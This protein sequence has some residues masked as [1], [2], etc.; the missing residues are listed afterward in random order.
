MTWCALVPCEVPKLEV[1]SSGTTDANF[2]GMYVELTEDALTF[3]EHEA[4]KMPYMTLMLRKIKVR[5]GALPALP[6]LL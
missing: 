1:G 3:Y 4:D 2:A 6:P 5:G